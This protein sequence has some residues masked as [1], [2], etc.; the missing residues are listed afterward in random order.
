M[1][2]LEGTTENLLEVLSSEGTTKN[3]NLLEVLLLEGTTE[4]KNFAAK[5]EVDVWRSEE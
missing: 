1:L 3:E 5:A 4:I 2:S